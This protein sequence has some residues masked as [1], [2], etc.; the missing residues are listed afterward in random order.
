MQVR[1]P[2]LQSFQDGGKL[3][4]RFLEMCHNKSIRSFADFYRITLFQWQS[5]DLHAEVKIHVPVHCTGIETG[6]QISRGIGQ[7]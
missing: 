6:I 1:Y 5:Q 7:A 4:A 2:N 3:A